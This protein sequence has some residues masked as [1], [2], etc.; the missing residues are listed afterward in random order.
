MPKTGGNETFD[1]TLAKYRKEIEAGFDYFAEEEKA[2]WTEFFDYQQMLV[3][4]RMEEGQEV[5]AFQWALS[6]VQPEGPKNVLEEIV[7]GDEIGEEL[8]RLAVGPSRPMYTGPKKAKAII[9]THGDFKDLEVSTF[10]VVAAHKDAEKRPLGLA[11]VDAILE[12]QNGT[13]EKLC[14]TWFKTAYLDPLSNTYSEEIEVKQ[15]KL[16]QLEQDIFL[17]GTQVFRYGLVLTKKEVFQ[18]EQLQV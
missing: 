16:K 14:T 2:W 8:L 9:E 17:Q 10:I 18:L 13:L 4:S 5:A 3:L 15:K 12:L 6:R 11:R 7:E 1:T